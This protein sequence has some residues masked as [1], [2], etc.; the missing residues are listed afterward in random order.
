MVLAKTNPIFLL[1]FKQTRNYNFEF[2]E[3]YLYQLHSLWFFLFIV[4]LL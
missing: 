4:L 3:N 1:L 2:K